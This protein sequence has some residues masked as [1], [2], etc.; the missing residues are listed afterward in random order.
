MMSTADSPRCTKLVA[1]SSFGQLVRVVDIR[2]IVGCYN[3]AMTNFCNTAW[4]PGLLLAIVLAFLCPQQVLAAETQTGSV[5]SVAKM[6]RDSVVLVAMTNRDGGEAGMGTGFAIGKDLIATNLHTIGEGRDIRVETR[7]G[8]PLEVVEVFASEASLDLAILRVRTNEELD[9][10]RLAESTEGSAT[11]E[12]G[13]QVVGIGH[14]LRLKD[15]VVSGLVAGDERMRGVNYWQLGMTIEPGASGSPLLDLEGRVHGVISM[16]SR[17]KEAFGFAIKIEHLRSLLEAPNP[18]AIDQWKTIGRLDANRWESKMGA[19]WRRRAGKLKVVGAGKGFGGRALLLRKDVEPELPFELAVSV[20][21]GDESG[22]AGLVFHSDRENQ[23]YGFYPSNGQMRLTSFEGPSV[24]SWNVVRDLPTE[25]YRP[26]EW[27]E[28]KVRVEKNQIV[29]FVNNR[30]VMRVEQVRQPPGAIGLCKFRNTAAEFRDFRFGE[31]VTSKVTSA[32]KIVEL[33]NQLEALNSRSSLLDIDLLGQSSMVAERL[34]V[35]ED[36][37]K[38]LERQANELRRLGQDIH[39]ATVCNDIARLTAEDDQDIDIL[40]GALLIS[41]LDNPELDVDSYVQQ[42][43]ETVEFIR[44]RF[45]DKTS[46]QEKLKLLDAYLFRENGFHGSRVDYYSQPSS[47]V[48]RAI[49]DREGLPITLSVL[50]ISM[51]QRLGLNVVGV[52]LPGHFVVRHEP[53]GAEDTDTHQLIDVFNRAERLSV[54]EASELVFQVTRRMPTKAAF[55][56][57]TNRS[58]LVR[59]L[60]NLM[61]LQGLPPAVKSRYAEGLVALEPESAQWRGIRGVFRHQLGRIRAAVDDMDWIL[62]K[63]PRGVDLEQVQRM[64]DAFAESMESV[65]QQPSDDQDE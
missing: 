51:A 33:T 19:T 21:L 45:S 13:Q 46:P 44:R 18:I 15:S 38:E 48:D 24:Y 63:Q 5:Q 56:T 59:M 52:G 36:K 1:L 37:A 26:G 49:D 42:V 12:S 4:R 32:E 17:E 41:K 55:E 9:A 58:I 11:L 14:P 65:Q 60:V 47:Y 3:V 54:N 40:R 25:H 43:G 34:S 22:A 6:A 61:G 35:L 30:E 20:K 62:E 2:R 7:D 10:L 27:N 23:H 8:D 57:S 16:K 53:N 28:L 29:G 39:V 31:K 64:R 50:Y